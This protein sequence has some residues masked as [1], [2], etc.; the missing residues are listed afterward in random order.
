MAG[1]IDI[2]AIIAEVDSAIGKAAK[3]V[4]DKIQKAYNESVDDFY[5]SYQP[6]SYIRTLS[7]YK[8]SSAARGHR[9]HRKL[10][11]MRHEAGITVDASY[12]GGNPYTKHP[13]HGWDP[14]VDFIFN[15]TFFE[16]IHGFNRGTIIKRNKR[17]P[18]DFIGPRQEPWVV[19]YNNS[20]STAIRFALNQKIGYNTP[21]NSTPPDKLLTARVNDIDSEVDAIVDKYLGW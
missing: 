18:Y 1:I 3:E 11:S 16:G 13:K 2:G 4:G 12:I 17:L 15:R 20:Y 10:G 7:T 9:T 6:S 14:S 8:G 5:D 21:T 19:G